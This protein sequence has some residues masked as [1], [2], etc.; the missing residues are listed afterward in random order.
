MGEF[1]FKEP[2]DF[3]VIERVIATSYLYPCCRADIL[4]HRNKMFWLF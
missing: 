2:V 3:S 4:E 1:G